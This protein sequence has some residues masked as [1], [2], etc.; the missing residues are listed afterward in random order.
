MDLTDKSQ[1]I[2]YLKSHG[3]YTKKS[4]GQNFLIDKNVLAEIIKAG[5]LKPTD[6]VVEIGPGLGTLTNELLK[7]C[8]KVIAVEKDEKLAE[9]LKL[10]ITHTDFIHRKDTDNGKYESRNPKS[11]PSRQA[12]GTN[13]INDDILNINPNELTANSYKLIAN[14]PYY[15]TSKILRHFLESENKPELIVMMTQKEVA[16]RICAKPGDMS[17]LSVS[18]QYYGEPE[19]IK[20]VKAES[21]FPKPEVESAILRIASRKYKVESIK[22]IEEEYFFKIVRAGFMARRKTLLNNLKTGTELQRD[23]ILDIMKRI[24]LKENARAQ[25]LSI[26]KWGQICQEIQKINK[27]IRK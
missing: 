24:G 16:E 2:G 20:T 18:V 25:E 9:I 3:L 14:I 23:E 17:L 15:I 19:I 27:T 5:E 22:G 21:F 26:N 7:H 12:G 10:N 13:I 1:L 8:K 4:L 6:T 11:L